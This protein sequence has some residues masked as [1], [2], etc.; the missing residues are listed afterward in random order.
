M[1]LIREVETSPNAIIDSGNSTT[2][3]LL[4]SA[5]WTGTW[6]DVTNYASLTVTGGSDVAGTLFVDAS[7]DGVSAFRITQLSDG[8][9]GSFGFHGLIPSAQYMRVRVVNGATPQGTLTIQTLVSSSAR[10]AMPTSRMS[11]TLTNYTDVM[12]VRAMLF[13]R[14]L[15]GQTFQNVDVAKTGVSNTGIRAVM[16]GPRAA[17]GDLLVA[18][19]TPRIQ[20]DAIY[21][22][23]TTDTEALTATGGTASVSGNQFSCAIDATVG[24]YAVIRSRRVI[25]Y[26]P[27]QGNRFRFTGIWPTAG[28]ANSFL[29]VGAFT[30]VDALTVGYNGTTFGFLRRIAGAPAIYRLTVTNGSG[31][32]ETVTITLNGVAFNV[33]TGGALSTTALAELLGESSVY[34]GWVAPTGTNRT[35]PTSN[36]A[37]VTFIQN[38]P[39][40]AAGAYTMTSSGTATGTFTQL[41]AGVA[42]DDTTG[43]VPKT[44]WNIDKCDGS[45]TDENPSGFNLLPDKLNVFQIV[46]PYLGAGPPTLYVMLPSENFVPVHQIEY[47]NNNT[48]PSQSNPTFRIGWIAASLGSSTALSIKGA[49]AGAFLDGPLVS[50]RDPFALIG[51]FAGATTSPNIY[52]MLAIRVGAVF[53]NRTNLREVLPL[54]LSLTVETTNRVVLVAAYLNPVLTGTTNW[55]YASSATSCVEYCTPTTLTPTNG[56]LIG[57]VSAGSTA[58]TLWSLHEDLQIRLEPGDVLAF[59]IQTVSGTATVGWSLNWHE[60]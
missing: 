2:T 52:V 7:T 50:P 20:I 5:T 47:P 25:R 23:V 57:G 27:G 24:A 4:A 34:T 9:N 26:M 29:M 48:I 44:S 12:N 10:I 53:G 39:A 40:V 42:N 37:T 56:Q 28:V 54:D 32:A 3:P 22:L 15:N 58:P 38:T 35:S 55:Q 33:A 21:G 45:N 19:A 13:G 8:T 30:A 51:T 41:E 6:L 18:Q 59:A 17:F 36:G 46:Y 49:S 14:D 60:L 43:F 1:S 16:E 31:G 11:Q